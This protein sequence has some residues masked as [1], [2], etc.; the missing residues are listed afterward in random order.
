MES[1]G[2]TTAS[3][4]PWDQPSHFDRAQF[5]DKIARLR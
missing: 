5:V 1:L 2:D 3:N 4:S